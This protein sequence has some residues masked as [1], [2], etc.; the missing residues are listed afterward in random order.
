MN[1][2]LSMSCLGQESRLLCQTDPQTVQQAELVLRLTKEHDRE[3]EDDTGIVF[4]GGMILGW[5]LVPCGP[6]ARWRIMLERVLPL[7]L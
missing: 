1:W 6:T 3:G 5:L 4:G 7:K 2:S